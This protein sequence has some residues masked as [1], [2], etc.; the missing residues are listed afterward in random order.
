MELRFV[1]TENFNPD[2]S[3]ESFRIS[4][5][6]VRQGWFVRVEAE[7]NDLGWC[8]LVKIMSG[9]NDGSWLK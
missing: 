3:L 5:S 4:L 8:G 7:Q 2:P 6:R 1:V 9:S